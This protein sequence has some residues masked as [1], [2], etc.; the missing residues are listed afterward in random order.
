MKESWANKILIVFCLLLALVGGFFFVANGWL[1]GNFQ[2]GL[3]HLT[4]IDQLVWLKS[5]YR[6]SGFDEEKT[7]LILFQNNLELRP[8][9]G[10]LGNF[11]IAKVKNGQITALGIH[12]TNIFD[13]F[14]KVQTM[15]PLPLRDYLNITNWQMRDSNWSPDFPTS[16]QKAEYFYHLQGGKERFD[17][18]IGVNAALLPGLLE[19]TG[20]LFL[21]D[22][23]KEFKAGDVLYQLEYEVEKGYVA[24]GIEDGERKSIFKALVKKAVSH[25]EESGLWKEEKFRSFLLSHLEKKNLMLFFPDEELQERIKEMDWAGKIDENWSDNYLMIV[26]ANLGGKKSNYFIKREAEY[27]IDLDKARPEAKIILGYH[28][29]GENKNW[30]SGDYRAYLKVYAPL[31]S[32][33]LSA[34]DSESKIDITK[35]LNKTVFGSWIVISTGQKEVIEI[36]YLLPE[37]FG[38]EEINQLLVQKQSGMGK[39]PLKVIIK[40]NGQEKIKEQRIEADWLESFS[41]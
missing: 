7:Y 25:I 37:G 13:G 26:E 27:L 31:G 6:V 8:S 15:P 11:G 3:S 28:H 29:Q 32:K 18:I 19:I 40:E 38:K 23:N 14:G 12:D 2:N 24:R 33:L 34:D 22:Y 30:F 1:A 16:A 36:K 5:L 20:P 39:F 17:G 10:Y 21:A 41:L 4:G 9:G 35:D